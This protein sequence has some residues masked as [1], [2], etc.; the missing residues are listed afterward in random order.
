MTGRIKGLATRI[1]AATTGQKIIRVW[2]GLHQL[3]LVMQ[4]CF[5]TALDENYLP[6]VR[7]RI[8]QNLY[9]PASAGDATVRATC[10]KLIE[11]YKQMT[12]MEGPIHSSAIAKMT[13][14]QFESNDEYVLEHVH[15][16]AFLQSLDIW[17]LE[18]LESLVPDTKLQLVVAVAKLFVKGASGISAIMAER[19]AANAAYDDTPLVLPHQLLSI[20]MPEFAQMIKQHTP[21]LSKTLDATEIHQISKEF[22]KLQ[23]CCERE[24]E[25]GKVIRA[26]DDNYKLGLL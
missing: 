6:G 12:H 21:R 25:L 18:A 9:R 23:R 19:D 26:A 8:Q 11:T 16:L 24:D 3:D 22:V 20:G 17:V 10:D 1:A 4:A 15:A 7:G 13:G 14:K 5:E 2:C